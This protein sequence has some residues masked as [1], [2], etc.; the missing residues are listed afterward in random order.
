MRVA[1]RGCG[2]APQCGGCG[3]LVRGFVVVRLIQANSE[4]HCRILA[5]LTHELAEQTVKWARTLA[6][7]VD[8]LASMLAHA[9]G[10]SFRIGKPTQ[11]KIL[12]REPA[13]GNRARKSKPRSGGDKRLPTIERKQPVSI[14]KTV[15]EVVPPE[16]WE[17]ASVILPKPR[18]T[19]KSDQRLSKQGVLVGAICTEILGIPGRHLPAT[20]AD[21]KTVRTHLRL[22]K[23]DG[24]WDALLPIITEH[25]NVRALTGEQATPGSRTR[26]PYSHPGS[27][28]APERPDPT[29]KPRTAVTAVLRTADTHSG[30]HSTRTADRPTDRKPHQEAVQRS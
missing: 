20:I 10:G 22:W 11:D 14:P 26:E 6:P 30:S 16:L 27:R 3:A 4:G 15:R 9:A 8:E 2:R 5:P 1:G 28:P 19:N 7:V 18:Q 17:R 21:R 12:M 13:S 24:T 29:G 23:A 25:P